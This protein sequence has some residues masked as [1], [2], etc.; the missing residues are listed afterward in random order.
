LI[1]FSIALFS[2]QT[3]AKLGEYAPQVLVPA[4][5]TPAGAP[6]GKPGPAA[7]QGTSS[8]GSQTPTSNS[9]SPSQASPQASSP[10]A[11]KG[12]AENSPGA[13]APF[14]NGAGPTGTNY[15]SGDQSTGATRG[16]EWNSEGANQCGEGQNM[17]RAVGNVLKNNVLPPGQ[18]YHI[19][20][21]NWA[22][23]D[24]SGTACNF[25]PGKL[26]MCT[27][28]TAAAFCQHFADLVNMGQLRLTPDQIN[29][30]NGPQVKA[31]ING[32]T[33]SMALLFQQLGGSSMDGSGANIENVLKQAKT[34]DV[35][36]IDRNNKTGHST[37]F[38]KLSADGKQFCYWT[39]NTGTNGAGIQC[40]N[41]SALSRAVVSRFPSDLGNIPGRIDKMRTTPPMSNLTAAQ[42]NAA[43]ANGIQ[44]AQTLKC[45][46]PASLT[47]AQNE[48]TA[49]KPAPVH[50]QK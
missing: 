7:V 29:F 27:S 25:G 10:Q 22:K 5:Q 9:N 38:Q 42:A 35:L 8:A 32:N 34:G 24:A 46:Q 36:K 4:G 44:F 41:I 21:P 18:G 16:G 13:K 23:L 19:N 49:A 37:I 30:L 20:A 26:S 40:E 1:I 15:N 48:A 31:A 45:D 33:Y 39:S 47:Q 3:Q 14:S 50:T 11:P 2:I 43:T 17:W 6:L 28:A 12:P